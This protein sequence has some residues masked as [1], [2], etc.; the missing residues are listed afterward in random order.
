[1][2]WLSTHTSP[3]QPSALHALGI[4]D[5]FF[6]SSGRNGHHSFHMAVSWEGRD[7]SLLLL[8]WPCNPS[9]GW[10]KAGVLFQDKEARRRQ[11]IMFLPGS[12]IHKLLLK[13]IKA[14]PRVT[15]NSTVWRNVLYW[16]WSPWG[17]KL[18][19]LWGQREQSAKWE[20][21]RVKCKEKWQETVRAGSH[22]E[23]MR[24]SIICGS[25]DP[26]TRDT[27]LW[28]SHVGPLLEC[29]SQMARYSIF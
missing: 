23:R 5:F 11:V 3:H 9:Q 24:L 13:E 17:L 2:E 25:S 4:P 18:K 26:Y 15:R 14:F 1:M 22:L 29:G 27:L 6:Q 7:S 19:C 28:S 20:E 8:P 16:E 12:Q 10:Q 21:H